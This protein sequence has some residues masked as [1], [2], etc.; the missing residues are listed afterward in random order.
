M[1]VYVSVWRRGCDDDRRHEFEDS[2]EVLCGGFILRGGV[3][4]MEPVMAHFC[5]M[6]VGSSGF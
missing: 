6:L 1:T 4:A 5:R 3:G 2:E